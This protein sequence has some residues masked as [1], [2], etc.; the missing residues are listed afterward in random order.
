MSAKFYPKPAQFESKSSIA[1]NS[2]VFNRELKDREKLLLLALNAI[3]VCAPTWEVCQTDLANR[4]GWSEGKMTDSIKICRKLGY[5]KTRQKRKSGQYSHNEFEFCLNGSYPKNDDDIV[6]EKCPHNEYKP[7]GYLPASVVP[8]S[9]NQGLPSSLPRSLTNLKKDLGQKMTMVVHKNEEKTLDIRKRW[10]LNDDQFESYNF[11]KSCEIDAEDKKLC[12]WAKTY[13]LQRLIDVFNEA[14]HN[15]ARSLRKYMSKL[16]DFG[17][18]V[19]NA[20][21]EANSS[22]AK[23]FMEINH[24]NTPKI[25]KNYMK[26]PI[27]VDFIEIN[28]DVD[29]A[30]FIRRFLEKYENSQR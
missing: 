30:E 8:T 2:L 22:F 5:I 26:I 11:L 10:A 1:P 20:R 23:D 7:T 14:K 15:K 27:G 16:L 28:F 24:W 4:L 9:V 29:S 25:F 17:K 12:Y 3:S 19:F 18:T 6:E 21:I 13:P